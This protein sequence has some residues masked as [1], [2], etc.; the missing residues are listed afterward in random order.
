LV[1]IDAK[2]RGHEPSQTNVSGKKSGGQLISEDNMD[3]IAANADYIRDNLP[4]SYTTPDTTTPDTTTPDTTTPDTTTPDTTT[5]D[6]TATNLTAPEDISDLVNLS[7]DNLDTIA[8]NADFIRDNL[9]GSDTTP[10]EPESGNIDEGTESGESL[11]LLASSTLETD[12]DKAKLLADSQLNEELLVIREEIYAISYTGTNR[13]SRITRSVAKAVR[14]TFV[15]PVKSF[16]YLSRS[17]FLREG[18][19]QL[20][21]SE[22]FGEREGVDFHN[23]VAEAVAKRIDLGEDW[24]LN[25]EQILR[26]DN[27]EVSEVKGQLNEIFRAGIVDGQSKTAVLESAKRVLAN[28]SW[29]EQGSDGAVHMLQNLDVIYDRIIASVDHEAGLA[30]I[31]AAYELVGG[32]VRRGAEARAESTTADKILEKLTNSR[33]KG[34]L[35]NEAT[36]AVAV[37]AAVSLVGYF[38]RSKGARVIAGALVGGPVGIAAVAGSAGLFAGLRERTTLRQERAMESE[39]VAL[40][41]AIG[42]VEAETGRRRAE[43]DATLYDMIPANDVIAELGHLIPAA[44]ET[45][46]EAT[47]STLFATLTSLRVNQSI[48]SQQRVDLIR[49][50]SEDLMEQERTEL[51]TLSAQAAVELRQYLSEHPDFMT[52]VPGVSIDD[53]LCLAESLHSETV[54]GHMSERDSAFRALTRTRVIKRAIA[55]AAFAGAGSYISSQITEH[56]RGEGAAPRPDVLDNHRQLLTMKGDSLDLPKGWKLEG[57]TLIDA[58]GKHITESFQYNPDGTLSQQTVTSLQ[59]SGIKFHEAVS[60]QTVTSTRE[61]PLDEYMKLHPEKFQLVKRDGWMGNNTPMWKDAQGNLHGAD[62]NELGGRFGTDGQ[63]NIILGT[64]PMTDTGSFQ[65]A[66]NV[67]AHSQQT[68][69][70]LK[71]ILTPN[72]SDQSHAIVLD[73]G[74][75]GNVL[76]PK[77]SEAHALFSIDPSGRVKLRTGFA[78][79]AS[80]TG[81]VGPNGENG[82]YILATQTG[83]GSPGMVTVTDTAD[84]FA[85]HGTL[86]VPDAPKPG[87]DLLVPFIPFASPLPRRPLEEI[88]AK[89]EPAYLSS[90]YLTGYNSS[91]FTPEQEAE[92]RRRFSPNLIDNPDALLEPRVEI[93]NYLE[94]EGRT[95]VLELERLAGQVEPMAETCQISVLMPV[96]GAQ[97]GANIYNTLKWYSG[98]LDADGNPLSP[99]SYE[100]VLLVNKPTDMEWDDTL[101][102]IERFK[103]D[104][105]GVTLRVVQKEYQRGS[106]T[107]GQIRKDLADL[108]LLR[109][110]RRGSAED[111]SLV[112]NDADCK[113]LG[114]TYLATIV[115]QMKA[116]GVDGLSGRLEWDPAT[117]LESPLYHMGVKIMQ[118][119]D[120]ID[121]HPRPG[122]G[123]AARYRYP[124]ANFAFSA[125]AYAAIGGYDAGCTKAED[126]VL[127][128]S[129]KLARSGSTSRKGVGFYGGDNVVYTDSRRGVQMFNEGYPPSMQWSKLSFGP[130]DEA[131][132]GVEL[133]DTINYDILLEEEPKGLTR[134]IQKKLRARFESQLKGFI[135]KTVSEY[136]LITSDTVYHEG[137]NMPSD[138]ELAVRALEALRIKA[139]V[140]VT[141]G[142]LRINFIDISR[143]YDYLRDSRQNGPKNYASRTGLDRIFSGGFDEV[144]S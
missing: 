27:P 116:Q 45:L 134:T 75:D 53:K 88:L 117:N 121:R 97:E 11:I 104:Y 40:G 10:D 95:R 107:I 60:S 115:E 94:R 34:L 109:Q 68:S 44:G 39:R 91:D 92:V 42:G 84:I 74:P 142:E 79:V 64:S 113:G 126:V 4:G 19:R 127:G 136:S 128:K 106:L 131:R 130:A 143:L 65:G 22:H 80:P 144:F 20:Y 98:Q 110:S 13:F 12:M 33:L 133:E 108:T 46:D 140:D 8:A 73:V 41:G 103:A 96:N 26:E 16:R 59:G 5:P 69:G 76:I 139:D 55:T 28:A 86:L 120:L 119:L 6:T 15:H 61:I 23:A 141:N 118:S 87:A 112:S 36:V 25:G 29:I 43:V 124:G 52:S 32:K 31:D 135:E 71:W 37:G 83:S 14:S 132:G 111:V 18:Y 57:S 63:G 49:Y 30:S 102:E 9:P 125:A 2:G 58:K 77:G 7:K 62:L 101:S 3:V 89:E 99:E 90:P 93:E 1:N 122:S 17:T 78:E 82:Y 24:L 35:V 48:G 70:Q 137:M 47:A 100:I 66:I 56:F 54:T 67:A 129:L 85:H 38:A 50:S 72:K 81:S 114:K 138:V 51:M 21:I 123:R 105:P